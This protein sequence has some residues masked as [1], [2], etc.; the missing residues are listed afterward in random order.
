[1]PSFRDIKAV[2]LKEL[3]KLTFDNTTAA[4]V[5]KEVLPVYNDRFGG[6]EGILT[7]LKVDKDKGVASS[8]VEERKKNFGVNK[9]EEEPQ[10]PLWKLMWEALQDPTLIFLSCAAIFSLFIAVFVERSAYGWLEGVAILFAVFVVVMVGAV[11]DYQKEKQ[12]RELNAKK[13]DVTITVFRDGKT[14]PVSTFNLV[15]GDVVL[16]STGDITPADGIVLGRNDLEINEKMLTGETVMKKKSATYEIQGSSVKS[17]PTLFAG[18]FVQAGQGRMLVVAVGTNTYQGTMEQKMKEAEQGRS[19]LQKKLDA[20][21]DLI[22]SVSM[23][24]SI[25]L[26][27]ILCARMFYA[28]QTKKCCME[29]I[30]TFH[31]LSMILFVLR[32]RFFLRLWKLTYPAFRFFSF[33]AANL[34]PVAVSQFC[35]CAASDC[36]PR[37]SGAIVR[38]PSPWQTRAVPSSLFRPMWLLNRHRRRAAVWGGLP[39]CPRAEA[40]PPPRRAVVG[41]QDP[42]VG[43]PGLRHHGHHHLRRRRPRRSGRRPPP[44][45]TGN[46]PP[47]PRIEVGWTRRGGDG[48]AA[49]ALAAD[50]AGS[51]RAPAGCDDCAGL[52]GEEDAQG[53]EPGAT[54]TLPARA[55]RANGRPPPHALSA[56]RSRGRPLKAAR[57]GVARRGAGAASER[58]RDHGRRDDHLLGQDGHAHDVAHDGAPPHTTT[59]LR[60]CLLSA[61]GGGA[62]LPFFPRARMWLN[63]SALWTGGEDVGGRLELLQPRHRR[64]GHSQGERPCRAP[65]PPPRPPQLWRRADT[66]RVEPGERGEGRKGTGDVQA[67]SA[68]ARL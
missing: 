66:A 67:V 3:V 49:A 37:P 18:T 21:T 22:T 16:L 53:P 33:C 38:H 6:L 47:A 40:R 42:L 44:P 59:P 60:P 19:I 4:D 14:I 28:F 57:R 7:S 17:S 9:I 65:P 5:T 1:M 50:R 8:E 30:L 12:F 52:L 45:P 41:P 46:H 23:Y 29:V 34:F 13:D 64:P 11:N 54:P 15:V 62:A 26:V 61:R 63:A 31:I 39:S 51:R 32:S 48:A 2:D 10:E 55:A 68:A 36:K 58:V 24:V 35:C 43:A 25:A 27:L 20:M 56:R